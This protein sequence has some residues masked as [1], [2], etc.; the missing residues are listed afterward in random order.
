MPTD[1]VTWYRLEMRPDG[2]V[3]VLNERTGEQ[4]TAA[5]PAEALEQLNATK[6][7]S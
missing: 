2:T 5:T 1:D 7:A 4:H 6:A 3:D